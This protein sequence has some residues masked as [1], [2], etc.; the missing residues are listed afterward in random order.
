MNVKMHYSSKIG[1]R[2]PSV[3]PFLCAPLCIHISFRN[4]EKTRPFPSF[5]FIAHRC[6]SHCFAAV[7]P[8]SLHSLF[9]RVINVHTL[10]LCVYRNSNVHFSGIVTDDNNATTT[11]Q[12]RSRKKV[13]NF[14]FL[15]L[16]HS[17]RC[18]V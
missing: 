2:R 4:I 12:R 5:P 18:P 10:Y 8:L 9:D 1:P 16:F 14:F 13:F 6:I 11:T 7:V 15:T 17:L 3:H